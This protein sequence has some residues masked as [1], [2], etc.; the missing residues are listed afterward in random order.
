MVAAFLLMVCSVAAEV[1]VYSAFTA[2]RFAQN[3]NAW[4]HLAYLAKIEGRSSP[5]TFTPVEWH[6]TMLDASRVEP[7][8][9]NAVVTGDTVTARVLATEAMR[10]K[11]VQFST[12]DFIN[13]SQCKIDSDQAVQIVS[14]TAP[15]QNAH[16][17]SIDFVL[18][19]DRSRDEPVWFLTI[20]GDDDQTI[21]NVQ[22]SAQTGEV[23]QSL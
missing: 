11:V 13:L 7:V 17:S 14:Q 20:I 5:A 16:I 9:F 23:I 12:K 21:G 18:Q 2:F 15:F 3:Q 4:G 1:I 10:T 19:Q 6:F 8:I 22:L